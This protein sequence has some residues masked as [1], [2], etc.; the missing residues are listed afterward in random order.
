MA[1]RLK[2]EPLVRQFQKLFNITFDGEEIL[3]VSC[4]KCGEILW[5]PKMDPNDNPGAVAAGLKMHWS[6]CCSPR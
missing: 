2:D 4:K 1:D 3:E 5:R 6:L